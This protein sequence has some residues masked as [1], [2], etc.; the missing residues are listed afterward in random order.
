MTESSGLRMPGIPNHPTIR[1]AL[2]KAFHRPTVSVGGTVRRQWQTVPARCLQP[3]DNIPGLGLLRRVV[4]IE[5]TPNTIVVDG[6]DGAHATYS[7]DDQVFAFTVEQ[8][9]P[10]N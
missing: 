8:T 5:T 1:R 3:G 6:G 2:P 10:P 7:A 9:A 4:V